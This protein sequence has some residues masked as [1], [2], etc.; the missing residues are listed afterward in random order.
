L[1]SGGFILLF[2]FVVYK[3]SVSIEINKFINKYMDK[4]LK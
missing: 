1:I 4:V 2:V 3:L